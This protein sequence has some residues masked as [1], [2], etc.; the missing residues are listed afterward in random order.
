[1][2][3]VKAATTEACLAAFFSSSVSGKSSL[4]FGGNCVP[5]LDLS[6]AKETFIF[7]PTLANMT[8]FLLLVLFLY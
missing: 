3:V 4:T 1:M 5:H 2:P 6:Q 7:V 8:V